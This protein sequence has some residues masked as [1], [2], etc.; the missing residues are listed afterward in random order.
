M[1]VLSQLSENPNTEDV[2]PRMSD[3]VPPKRPAGSRNYPQEVKGEDVVT[4][5][6]L[7]G[8]DTTDQT[9]HITAKQ[10]TVV[11]AERDYLDCFV[12]S[13]GLSDTAEWRKGSILK[14]MIL[15]S[16]CQPR[17]SPLALHGLAQAWRGLATSTP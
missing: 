11:S 4:P 8:H 13:Q 10:E 7:P 15:S 2:P 16:A 1:C 12:T 14:L 9:Y 3:R 6:R 17:T 5:A